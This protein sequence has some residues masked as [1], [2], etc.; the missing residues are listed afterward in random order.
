MFKRLS[1]RWYLYK[2]DKKYKQNNKWNISIYF[3]MAVIKGFNPKWINYNYKDL[4]IKEIAVYTVSS[5]HLIETMNRY[6]SIIENNETITTYVKNGNYSKQLLDLLTY[7][8]DKNK[9]QNEPILIEEKISESMQKIFIALEKI[10]KDNTLQ[11]KYY[12]RQL[13]PIFNDILEVY[14]GFIQLSSK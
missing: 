11:Y 8:T 10:R 6:L 3:I 1:I 14:W 2:L 7:F 5:D 9:L 4:L 13:D 12:I